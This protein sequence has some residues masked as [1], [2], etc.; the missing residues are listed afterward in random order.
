M[1][2]GNDTCKASHSKLA[3]VKPLCYIVESDNNLWF[4]LNFHCM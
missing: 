3:I 1:V 2:H 4:I